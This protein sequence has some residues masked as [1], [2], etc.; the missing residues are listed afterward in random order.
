M[1]LGVGAAATAEMLEFRVWVR[2]QRW[3]SWTSGYWQGGAARYLGV[4]AATTGE[5]VNFRVLAE[6]RG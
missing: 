1:Y 6:G 3:R 2:R 4:G 5:L